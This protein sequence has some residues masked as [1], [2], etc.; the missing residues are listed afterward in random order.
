M[1]PLHPAT[2]DADC[3][4]LAYAQDPLIG[5]PRYGLGSATR[6]SLSDLSWLTDEQIAR[7]SPYLAKSHGKSLVDDWRVLSGD[8][9]PQP[10]QPGLA[11]C[12]GAKGHNAL[13]SG[14]Q[15][16]FLANQIRQTVVQ[17]S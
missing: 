17:T 10:E 13:H 11:E 14:P 15:I 5:S 16:P 6:L 2:Y 12:A 3:A 7:L 4:E 9:L 8:H 1:P